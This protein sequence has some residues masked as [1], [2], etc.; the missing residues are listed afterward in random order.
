MQTLDGDTPLTA[1]ETEAIAKSLLTPESFEILRRDR[2]V[3]FSFSWEDKARL[4]GNAFH[5]RDN[6]AVALRM[7]PAAIPT[8]SDL[9]L[10]P[11]LEALARLPQGFVLVTGPTGSGKTT[12][13]ASVLEWVNENRACHIVTLEDPIE[14]MHERKRSAVS[15]REIGTDSL[16][17]ARGLRS[18]L[19]ED[20]DVLLVGEM[21][22]P[23]SIQTTL[24]IAE[25]GH[26]VFATLH[27]NDASQALDRI[28]DVFPAE[29][30]V[31]VK[32]QLASSLAGIVSQRLVPK[33]GG[34][35]VAAFEVLT[36]TTAVRNLVK[37]GKTRQMRNQILTG[38]RHGMLTLEASLSQLV[39]DGLV[40]YDEAVARSLFPDEIERPPVTQAPAA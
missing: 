26:L 17:F 21:R 37:E 29:S 39:R 16:S 14:Y 8:P 6:I 2:E 23:E 10:P 13:L 15:Q 4:R 31:Q 25:T 32:I 12:T 34:G 24:T 3:D 28:I 11:A 33:I 35:R 18:A 38:Q 9:R 20:P 22:D 27:T 5:T 19:R 36:A 30:Q 40:S 7:I 1:D